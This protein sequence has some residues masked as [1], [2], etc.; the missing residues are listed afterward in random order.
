M[1]LRRTC[2]ATADAITNNGSERWPH[3]CEYKNLG[4]AHCFD[5]PE[6]AVAFLGYASLWSAIAAD[7]GIPLLVVFNALRLLRGHEPRQSRSG[8]DR[9]DDDDD[10]RLERPEPHRLRAAF[11]LAQL[12]QPLYL[13]EMPLKSA[14]LRRGGSAMRQHSRADDHVRR[15]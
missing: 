8:E 6:L 14:R 9:S 3:P 12:G 11:G 10:A 1:R 15:G 13:C 7:T 4:L 2:G 5:T